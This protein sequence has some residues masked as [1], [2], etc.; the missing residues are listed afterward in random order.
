MWSVTKEMTLGEN[1]VEDGMVADVLDFIGQ[2]VI[3]GANKLIE[4]SS[5]LGHTSL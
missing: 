3:K 5:H 4:L 1:R 2:V